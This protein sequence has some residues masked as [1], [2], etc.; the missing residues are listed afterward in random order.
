MGVGCGLWVVGWP[1]CL[2]VWLVPAGEVE[3][4]GTEQG[5]FGPAGTHEARASAGYELR[6]ALAGQ[7]D[8][9]VGQRRHLSKL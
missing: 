8:S 2:A 6:A 7:L 3:Y 1:G 5:K 9:W 4:L